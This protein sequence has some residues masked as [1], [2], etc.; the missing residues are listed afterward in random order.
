MKEEVKKMEEINEVLGMISSLTCGEL[1]KLYFD[2]C[3]NL[4]HAFDLGQRYEQ[5]IHK[6]KPKEE[7][8]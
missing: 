6:G 3:T 4:W 1:P 8:K 2:N 5:L 7:V